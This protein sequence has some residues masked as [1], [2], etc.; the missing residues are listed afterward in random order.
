MLTHFPSQKSRNGGFIQESNLPLMMLNPGRGKW[1]VLHCFH[2][3]RDKN[4]ALD[5]LRILFLRPPA[6]L[7]IKYE[8]VLEIMPWIHKQK[9]KNFCEQWHLEL[10]KSSRSF[11]FVPFS[12]TLQ[13]V[14]HRCHKGG[15]NSITTPRWHETKKSVKKLLFEQWDRGG[16]GNLVNPSGSS[17]L[18]PF[19]SSHAFFSIRPCWFCWRLGPV[20]GRN[21]FVPTAKLCSSCSDLLLPL[22][23]DAVMIL[24]EKWYL[25]AMNPKEFNTD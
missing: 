24:P 9:K 22:C 23:C 4:A 12:P 3:P 15:I 6:F 1:T 5:T 21:L 10:L 18:L 11:S 16:L 17:F 14:S 8:G 25:P 2:S 13:L 7:Y 20:P 19:L